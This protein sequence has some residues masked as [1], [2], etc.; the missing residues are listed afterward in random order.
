MTTAATTCRSST[1]KTATSHSLKR[2]PLDPLCYQGGKGEDSSEGRA[3]TSHEFQMPAQAVHSVILLVS[4]GGRLQATSC[5]PVQEL[6]ESLF[7][8]QLWSQNSAIRLD[9][10]GSCSPPRNNPWSLRMVSV[11]LSIAGGPRRQRLL[12]RIPWCPHDSKNDSFFLQAHLPDPLWGGTE[13]SAFSAVPR[14]SVRQMLV[15]LAG[16]TSHDVN[17]KAR[18]SAR[19]P[20][21]SIPGR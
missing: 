3:A 19:L 4:R 8:N 20:T 21:C 7:K 11:Q 12:S 16:Q 14:H 6:Q 5:L 10:A 13:N 17:V 2:N 1:R 9:L 18:P 15:T